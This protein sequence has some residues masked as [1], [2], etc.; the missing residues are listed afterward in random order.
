[1]HTKKE[2]LELIKAVRDIA[3]DP[4]SAYLLRTRVKR[5]LLSIGRLAAYH[6]GVEAPRLPGTMSLPDQAPLRSRNLIVSCN[7][8]L[9]STMKLCQP[10]EALDTR[11]NE[12]WASVI[13]ELA[14]IEKQLMDWPESPSCQ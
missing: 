4:D 8:L 3:S 6:A 1:M 9:S 2:C 10:S 12:G 14:H 5:A 11:W 7:C 13:A